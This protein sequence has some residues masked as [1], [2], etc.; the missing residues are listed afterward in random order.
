MTSELFSGS[1]VMPPTKAARRSACTTRSA[2][3]KPWP[4]AGSGAV[5]PLGG[6]FDL[7]WFTTTVT[8]R[9]SPTSKV[10]AI[11]L[12]AMSHTASVSAKLSPTGVTT[13]G[14]KMIAV[15]MM[16]FAPGTASTSG[17]GT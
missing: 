1:A 15:V 12:R 17:V 6:D 3:K 10:W 13:D 7:K 11:G 8:R 9:S 16:S 4:S 5:L 14:L 2:L